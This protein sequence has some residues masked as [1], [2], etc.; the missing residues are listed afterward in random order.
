MGNIA[1]PLPLLFRDSEALVIDKPMGLAVDPPRDGSDSV[2]AR[3][4]AWMMGYAEIPAP[5]HRL[6]RDTSGCL[7]LARSIKA[8][9]RLSR[10]FAEGRVEKLYYA[11][12][13]GQPDAAEGCIDMP[14]GKKSSAQMGWRIVPDQHGKGSV[15]H[16]RLVE[17]RGGYSLLALTPETGRTH[18]LRVH[19][20]SGLGLPIVGDAVYGKGDPRGMMLHAASISLPRTTKEA[21]VAHAPLPERFAAFGFGDPNG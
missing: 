18:Q 7:I 10:A 16:W 17:S 14:L 20:A 2:T 21:I 8:H 1:K 11:I 12:V 9:R 3:A 19:L 13:A 6:D 15:T 5:I 4:E